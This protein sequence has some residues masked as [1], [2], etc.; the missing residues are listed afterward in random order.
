MKTLEGNYTLTDR[1]RFT[2]S[3]LGLRTRRTRFSKINRRVMCDQ[4]AWTVKLSSL[5][6]LATLAYGLS[7]IF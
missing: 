7:F 6:G 2:I 4:L 5:A 3:K 1:E